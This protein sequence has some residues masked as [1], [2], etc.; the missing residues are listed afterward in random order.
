M[1]AQKA[2]DG[3]HFWSWG[4]GYLYTVETC[5]AAGGSPADRVVTRTGFRK[6]EFRD[7]RFYLND[8]CLM[9]HGYAQRSSNEWPGTGLSVPA[10]L[11]DYSNALMVESGGN[12]VRWMHVTP[13]K[14]DVES[15]DRVG[16]LQAMPAGDA[17]KDVDGPRWQQR[18]QLMRDAIVYNRNNPSVCFYECG[19]YRISKEHIEEMKQL[20]DQY[21]PYGG[22]AAWWSDGMSSGWSGPAR[23]GASAAAA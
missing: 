6:T 10:W 15:C 4:Y 11:S 13:W 3:L 16:L 2:L 20:R 5:L 23:A 9:V 1:T 19:N 21:D 14:Q 12:I 17:E 7:G 8:R 22:R 18:T